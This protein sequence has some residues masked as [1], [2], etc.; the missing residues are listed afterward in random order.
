MYALRSDTF[1][2]NP[3]IYLL[4]GITP[5]TIETCSRLLQDNHEHYHVFFNRERGF[6]NHTTHHLLAALGLGAS[7]QA[8]ERI[9]NQHKQIQQSAQPL[10]NTKE[11]D[12]QKCLGDD[13]YYADYSEFFRKELENEKYH[14][15]IEELI[16][17]YVFNK[18]YLV[19]IFGGAYHAFIH[20]GYALEFQVN[21]MAIEGLA[22]ASVD[23]F[24]VGGVL[25]HLKYDENK[26]GDKTALDIIKLICEDHRFDDKVFYSDE[27]ITTTYLLQRGGGPLIAEYAQMWK[28]DLNDLRRAGVLVNAGVIRPKKAVRLNFFL[29]HATTSCLFLEIFIRSLKKQ[30]NQL[31]FLRAKFAVDLL[32]YV[33]YG[34]PK[35]NLNY[36]LNE[37]QP[38]KE[39]S[40]PDAQNPW[41]PLVDKCLTHPD[42]HLPKTIRA[43]IYA[44][45]FDN[46]SEK[47]KLPYLKIAQMNM[48]ALFPADQKDWTREGIGFDEYWKTVEDL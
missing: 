9:Y 2:E 27:G 38:S 10:H 40:Y 26:D 23:R 29:M 30:E 45:K 5:E 13:N 14:G 3:S 42:E 36:L 16:E 28:C 6:H 24:G 41:L 12:L 20:L 22:M 8:L 21:V 48:D 34:R 15:N 11:F 47:D 25:E 4:P 31:K 19:L 32:W 44:E 35:L 18:D 17:D 37:Y 46:T 39:H 43:L 33:A 7:S 1:I